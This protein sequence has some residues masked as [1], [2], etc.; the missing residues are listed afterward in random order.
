MCCTVCVCLLYVLCC[1]F[2]RCRVTCS[3]FVVVLCVIFCMLYV[4]CVMVLVL[5][6]CFMLYVSCVMFHVLWFM[7]YVLCCMFYDTCVTCYVL[8]CMCHVYCFVLYV[9]CFAVYVFFYS[10]A[11]TCAQ[12]QT[13]NKKVPNPINTCMFI[14]GTKEHNNKIQKQKPQTSAQSETYCN[15]CKTNSLLKANKHKRN[16]KQG[17]KQAPRQQTTETH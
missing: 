3:V 15:K 14:E 10:K 13:Y 5:C 2:H 9:L 11:A 17:N 7:F 12:S 1:M 8:C 6:L 16:N 4:L